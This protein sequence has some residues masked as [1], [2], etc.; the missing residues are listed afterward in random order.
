MPTGRFE[1]TYVAHIEG[2]ELLFL[3]SC[4]VVDWVAYSFSKGSS[5]LSAKLPGKPLNYICDSHLR[6]RVVVS[7]S[8]PLHRLYSPPGSSVHDIPQARILEWVAISSSRVCSQPTI[9]PR[10][11]T[12]AHV[13]FIAEPPGKPRVLLLTFCIVLF[14]DKLRHV[15]IFKSL[16]KNQ[17]ELESGGRAEWRERGSTR[18]WLMA[19]AWGTGGRVWFAVPGILIHNLEAFTV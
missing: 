8:L 13:F 10:S 5:P 3:F 11:P 17:F 1:I 15:N 9:K 4:W 6:L 16:S 7:D 2:Q 12:L 14:K 18:T 19:A